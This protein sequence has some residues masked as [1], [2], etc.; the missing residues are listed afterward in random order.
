MKRTQSINDN[1]EHV[2]AKYEQTLTIEKSNTPSTDSAHQ[3]VMQAEK[4]RRVESYEL[5]A[6]NKRMQQ[7]EMENY[8]LRKQCRRLEKIVTSLLESKGKVSKNLY[9]NKH[10]MPKNILLFQNFFIFII[11][12]MMIHDMR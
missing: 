10:S 6:S 12:T 5:A 3:S 9:K 1:E 2:T 8:S 11:V 7:M 4:S